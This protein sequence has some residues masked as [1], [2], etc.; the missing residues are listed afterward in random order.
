[1]EVREKRN[2]VDL[3]PNYSQLQLVIRKYL[4]R[5]QNLPLSPHPLVIPSSP[6]MYIELV[7]VSLVSARVDGWRERGRG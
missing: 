2:S 5:L 7:S 6:Q 4:Q 1:M 3:W